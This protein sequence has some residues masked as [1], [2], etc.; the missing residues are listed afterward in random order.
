M[1]QHRIVYINDEVTFIK[2]HKTHRC[3]RLYTIVINQ[4]NLKEVT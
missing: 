1:I 2:Q 3:T 4:N